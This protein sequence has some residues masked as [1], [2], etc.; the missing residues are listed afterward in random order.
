MIYPSYRILNEEGQY[1]S[2]FWF[3]FARLKYLDRNPNQ[4]DDFLGS[5]YQKEGAKPLWAYHADTEITSAKDV[6]RIEVALHA[7]DWD[8]KDVEAIM[9][10]PLFDDMKWH[11]EGEFV[12]AG[13][14]TEDKHIQ[15]IMYPI[16]MLRNILSGSEVFPLLRERGLSVVEAAFL[17]SQL[18]VCTNFNGKKY[19]ERIGDDYYLA[20]TLEGLALVMNQKPVYMGAKWGVYSEGYRETGDYSDLPESAFDVDCDIDI[21]DITDEIGEDDGLNGFTILADHFKQAMETVN[22]KA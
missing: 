3:C 18:T 2:F 9:G 5:H 11:I 10:Q 8:V 6:T 12:V 22:A 13:I 17:G 7:P 20:K 19:A 21:E 16:F 1:Q 15:A 14:E 4:Y